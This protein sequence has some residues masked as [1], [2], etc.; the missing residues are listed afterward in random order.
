[1]EIA[2]LKKTIFILLRYALQNGMRY[3]DNDRLLDN[4]YTKRMPPSPTN[5]AL[6]HPTPTQKINLSQFLKG[7]RCQQRI[8]I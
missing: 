7:L 1:M 6:L 3:T 4:K 5:T 8:T 2:I